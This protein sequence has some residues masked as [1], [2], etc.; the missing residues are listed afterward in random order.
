MSEKT[1]K[2]TRFGPRGKAYMAFFCG[3]MCLVSYAATYYGALNVSQASIAGYFDCEIS[4]VTLYYTFQCISSM[5]WGLLG[6]WFLQKFNLHL[7]A[8][9]GGVVGFV[10]AMICAFANGIWGI[11]IGACCFGFC[12][13]MCGPA[14]LQTI[15]SAWFYKGRATLLGVGGMTEPLGTTSLSMLTAWFVT[16]YGLGA[17]RYGLIIGGCLM[18]ITGILCYFMMGGTPADFGF[19]ALGAEGTAAAVDENGEAAGIDARTMMRRSC[20]WIF[21][22]SCLVFNIGYSCFQPQLSGRVQSLGYTAIQAAVAVSIWSWTKGLSKIFYGYIG[23]RWGMRVSLTCFSCVAVVLVVIYGFTT[24]LPIIYLGAIGIGL[25]GG[26][27][28]SFTL[29]VSRMSGPKGLLGL[30]TIP[31]FFGGFGFTVGPIIFNTLI[32]TNAAGYR[33]GAFAGSA[34]IIVY[35]VLMYIALNPKNMF[36]KDR[37]I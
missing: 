26:I 1:L 37:A 8:C 34:L 16:S 33:L 24:S 23:D 17:Y 13:N 10:G 18:L 9:I 35:I 2:K 21:M 29:A 20:F 32:T 19:S 6:A 5:V 3:I 27:S 22:I 36:E 30:A 4:K 25:I 7:S 14:M 11:Y 15:T 28:G 31:H 12:V